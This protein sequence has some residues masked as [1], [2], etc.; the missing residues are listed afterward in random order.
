MEDDLSFVVNG[1]SLILLVIGRQPQSYCEWKATSNLF[2][3]DRNILKCKL[4]QL[5]VASLA[6]S[7][8]P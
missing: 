7:L 6:W 1:S 3:N 2:V 8:W 4:G 5:A